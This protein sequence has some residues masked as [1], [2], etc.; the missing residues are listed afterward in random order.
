MNL[1]DLTDIYNEIVATY[2]KDKSLTCI[3]V[4]FLFNKATSEKNTALIN[5]DFRTEETKM[6]IKKLTKKRLKKNPH[7]KPQLDEKKRK[8]NNY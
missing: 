2:K 1:K 5:V 3:Q 6:K 4:N 8:R 7:A